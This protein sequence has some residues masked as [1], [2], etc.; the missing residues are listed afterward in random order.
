MFNAPIFIYILAKRSAVPIADYIITI[1]LELFNVSPIRYRGCI[2][3]NWD[4]TNRN[5]TVFSH[6]VP[7]DRIIIRNVG[8]Q[9]RFTIIVV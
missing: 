7:I 3:R 5:K 4:L 9:L 1:R 6:F 2:S 8:M